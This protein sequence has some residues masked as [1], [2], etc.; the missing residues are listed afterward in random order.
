M[1]NIDLLMCVRLLI[2]LS[3]FASILS[4]VLPMQIALGGGGPVG[5]DGTDF[6]A[7]TSYFSHD[8]GLALLYTWK[9]W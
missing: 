8:F 5:W 7:R 9:K 4:P 2:S 1:H 6:F 3:V